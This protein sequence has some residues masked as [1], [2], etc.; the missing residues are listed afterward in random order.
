MAR[1]LVPGGPGRPVAE[2]VGNLPVLAGAIVDLGLVSGVSKIDQPVV[3]LG[4][5]VMSYL[6]GRRLFA[7]QIMPSAVVAR[8]TTKGR[9]SPA[10]VSLCPPEVDETQAVTATVVGNRPVPEA[11]LACCRVNAAPSQGPTTR[12]MADYWGDQDATEVVVAPTDPQRWMSDQFA[13]PE[14]RPCS[15]CGEPLTVAMEGC[16]FCGHVVR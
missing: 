7:V 9:L 3:G 1:S 13:Q 14:I 6:P 10:A 16:A 15:W 8:V 11:V 5:H 4:H 2:I 12:R